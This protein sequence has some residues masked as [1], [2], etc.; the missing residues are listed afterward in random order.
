MSAKQEPYVQ[1]DDHSHVM[2]RKNNVGEMIILI[3]CERNSLY[4][5]YNLML[6]Q[7]CKIQGLHI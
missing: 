6:H 5:S 3:K 4:W 7:M 1:I 2:W